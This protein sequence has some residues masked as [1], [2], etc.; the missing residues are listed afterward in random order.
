ET[1]YRLGLPGRRRLA[2][3]AVLTGALRQLRNFRSCLHFLTCGIYSFIAA[4][5]L[6]RDRIVRLR[7]LQFKQPLDVALLLLAGL[8]APMV[9]GAD[10]VTR[11]VLLITS[12]LDELRFDTYEMTRHQPV[13]AVNDLVLV[14]DNRM[15]EPAALDITGELVQFLVF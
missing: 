4:A 1:D 9:V 2:R 5:D 11:N 10:D 7:W 15:N 12:V 13:A 3:L 8:M 14:D 6:V